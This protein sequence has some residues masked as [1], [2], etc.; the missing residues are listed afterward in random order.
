VYAEDYQ[1]NLLHCVSFYT[2]LAFIHTFADVLM[3]FFSIF[4][5]VFGGPGEGYLLI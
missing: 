4:Y 5:I 2:I 1:G 3:H